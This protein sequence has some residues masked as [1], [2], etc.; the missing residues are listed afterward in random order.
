MLFCIDSAKIIIHRDINKKKID[1]SMSVMSYKKCF[2]LKI[3]LKSNFIQKVDYRV[4]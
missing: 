2:V 3:S 1:Q 4:T